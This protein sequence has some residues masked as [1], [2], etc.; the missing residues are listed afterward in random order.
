M[1]GFAVN[2]GLSTGMTFGPNQGQSYRSALKSAHLNLSMGA[3]NLKLPHQP[4]VSQPGTT[5]TS[6]NNG[7]ENGKYGYDPAKDRNNVAFYKGPSS[8]SATVDLTG[9]NKS[10]ALLKNENETRCNKRQLSPAGGIN[11]KISE[12]GFVRMTQGWL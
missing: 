6:V 5:S 4:K 2:F 3:G 12:N 7:N 11:K 8:Q 1:S 9:Q 10:Q